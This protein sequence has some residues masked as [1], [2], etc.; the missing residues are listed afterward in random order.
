MNTPQKPENRP[1]ALEN[2]QMKSDLPGTPGALPDH[3]RMPVSQAAQSI[4][5]A[6]AKISIHRSRMTRVSIP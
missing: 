1:A 3:E 4:H 5:Q 2:P 6:N